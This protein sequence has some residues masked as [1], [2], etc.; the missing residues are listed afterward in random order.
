MKWTEEDRHEFVERIADGMIAELTFEVMRQACWDNLYDDLM[1]VE[2]V[3]L[4]MYA[5]QYAPDL[6]TDG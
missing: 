1:C 3:D 4:L 2:W 6:L 5:E